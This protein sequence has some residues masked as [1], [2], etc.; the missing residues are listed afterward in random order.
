[1]K[2]LVVLKAI[3]VLAAFVYTVWF[4][5][6]AVGYLFGGGIEGGLAFVQ[7]TAGRRGSSYSLLSRLR[8]SRRFTV[9]YG[10]VAGYFFGAG[11]LFLKLE[12]GGVII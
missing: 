2:V 6:N 8:F 3:I 1:M 10:Q 4:V 7:P 12:G 11:Q 5:V 9:L